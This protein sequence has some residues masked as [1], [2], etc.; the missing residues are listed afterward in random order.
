M[1]LQAAMT[2]ISV[3]LFL[4][5]YLVQGNPCHINLQGNIIVN[6][7]ITVGNFG[8]VVMFDNQILSLR[9]SSY[10]VVEMMLDYSDL[11]T[12]GTITLSLTLSKCLLQRDIEV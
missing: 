2:G 12:M 7:S 10:P 1:F 5:S 4:C 9:N 11:L 3:N 8:A 6:T